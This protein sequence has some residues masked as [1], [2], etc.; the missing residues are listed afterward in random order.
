MMSS[1]PGP[2]GGRREERTAPRTAPRARPRRPPPSPRVGAGGGQDGSQAV[3]LRLLPAALCP[4]VHAARAEAARGVAHPAPPH[5]ESAAPKCRKPVGLS[6]GLIFPLDLRTFGPPG[7]SRCAPGVGRGGPWGRT[8]RLASDSCFPP[9]RC[10]QLGKRPRTRSPVPTTEA[11]LL[12][13]ETPLRLAFIYFNLV[14]RHQTLKRSCSWWGGGE[15]LSVLICS[16]RLQP[17][18]PQAYFF[19]PPPPLDKNVCPSCPR[20]KTPPALPG[21]WNGLAPCIERNP[22]I[23][24]PLDSPQS[25]ISWQA[26][27]P[28]KAAERHGP[29]S[30]RS[31]HGGQGR[32]QS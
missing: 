13:P 25:S 6:G 26:A 5:G 20:H 4:S 9:W 3:W 31:A 16:I 28:C 27:L 15:F 7:V 30:V 21:P 22:D 17:K 29:R 2:R 1:L 14:D 23:L 19:H 12:H 32:G 10:N 8:G 18:R 24:C 11:G